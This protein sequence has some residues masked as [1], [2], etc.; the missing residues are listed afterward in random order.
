MEDDAPEYEE[1]EQTVMPDELLPISLEQFI[2]NC[3][4]DCVEGR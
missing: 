2:A 3:A 1:G 4:A